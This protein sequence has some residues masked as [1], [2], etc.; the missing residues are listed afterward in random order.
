MTKGKETGSGQEKAAR[1]KKGFT[2]E[3]HTR[4]NSVHFP[5]FMAGEE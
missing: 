5:D 1:R 4:G 3:F 2:I